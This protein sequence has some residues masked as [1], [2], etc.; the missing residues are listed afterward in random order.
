MS[1]CQ[2]DWSFHRFIR[3][4]PH[5]S[6]LAGKGEGLRIKKNQ[7]FITVLLTIP[8]KTPLNSLSGELL[9]NALGA[10]M[11]P[12]AVVG[13]HWTKRCCKQFHISSPQV[14]SKFQH[15]TNPRKGVKHRVMIRPYKR[16]RSVNEKNLYFLTERSNLLK[17]LYCYRM[18]LMW[19]KG[20]KS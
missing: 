2:Y 16:C 12:G 13:N 10:I 17:R 1:L 6:G 11:F 18:L 5:P 15:S 3:N 14:T 8:N 7:T 4:K 19:Y 20:S 9:I